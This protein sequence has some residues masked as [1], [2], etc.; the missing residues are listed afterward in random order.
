MAAASLTIG[1]DADDTLWHNETIF[2]RVHER[3]QTLLARYHDAA[4]VDRT[5]FATEMRNLELYGYGVKAFMLSSIETAIALSGGHISAAEIQQVLDLGREMLQHPVELLDGVAETV[6]QLAP[7]HRVLLI[8]KGDLRDQERKLEKSGLAVHFSAVE[9]VSEKNESTYAAILRRHAVDPRQFLMV[10][11]SLKSDIQ[12]VLALGGL[13]ALHPVSPHVGRRAC[14]ARPRSAR[15]LLHPW[16]HARAADAGGGVGVTSAPHRLPIQSRSLPLSSG[17]RLGPYEITSPIGAGGMGEV[18]KAR[19]TRLDRTVAIKILSDTLAADPQFRERFDREGRA[20]SQLTHPHICTLY[21]VGQHEGT[22]FLVMEY[23]DGGTLAD[24]LAKGALPV[25]QALKIA[26]EI[27]SALDK[28][29]RAGIVHRD[30]KPGN[31]MLTRSGAKLLDFGLA[32]SQGPVLARAGESMLPTTPA[33][34]TDE[35][36]CS[37]RS[38]TWRPSSSRARRRTRGPICLRSG[39]CS[40]RCW[41]GA[42]PSRAR[43]TQACSGRFSRTSRR[44]CRRAAAGAR[45][46]RPR[47]RQVP[48]KGPRRAVAVRARP[49]RRA[50]VDRLRPSPIRSGRD[51]CG[52]AAGTRGMDSGGRDCG[53][54]AGLWIFG[55]GWRGRPVASDAPEMRLQILTPADASIGGFALSP[56]R[57][58]IVYKPPPMADL[59][60]GFGCSTPT[61]RGRWRA[62]TALRSGQRRSGRRTAVRSPFSRLNS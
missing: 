27:A 22:A 7:R 56:D 59:G 57:R 32:K 31:I 6:A 50:G 12:P 23:L 8:T 33:N 29:H 19:D 60:Y 46:A 34:L 16:K 14:R 25:D 36:R 62:P 21:D 43:R 37:G 52:T 49:A 42:G 61:R 13:G 24:R 41:R 11:N 10:G 44:R 30:L 3:F 58:A 15:T 18:Y 20:V 5:L 54:S 55:S 1:F 38:S 17:A 45:R 40:T 39:W 51:H 4:T 35:A 26:I 9:I 53:H 47:R 28:A 2:E 48:G